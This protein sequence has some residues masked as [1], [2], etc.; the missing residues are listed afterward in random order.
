[1][2]E[3]EE[4][5]TV[6]SAEAF[7]MPRDKFRRLFIEIANELRGEYGDH[8]FGNGHLSILRDVDTMTTDQMLK[9]LADHPDWFEPKELRRGK[10]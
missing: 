3:E 8:P 7:R 9:I 6:T 5:P 1:M 4:R 2:K 10:T